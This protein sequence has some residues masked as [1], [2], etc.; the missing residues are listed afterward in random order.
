[1]PNTRAEQA[2]LGTRGGLNSGESRR[3]RSK[4]LALAD[5]VEAVVAGANELTQTQQ[6]A[7]RAILAPALS[8]E[9]P[10][11]LAS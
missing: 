1:M 8:E 9:Q 5:H 4:K 7:L 3:Q 6:T 11:P 2:T 10:H